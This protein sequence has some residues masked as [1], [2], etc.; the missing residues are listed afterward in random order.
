MSELFRN[1]ERSTEEARQMEA[2][3]RENRLNLKALLFTLAIVMAPFFALI[4]SVDLAMGVLAA[5]LGFT[6]WL[7]W[8]A[9]R[10]VGPLLSSRLRVVA[11]LNLCIML[12]V[13]LI[14]VLHLR[15]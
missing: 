3:R 11:I 15:A 13:L 12:V 2:I 9:S 10:D 7:T 6:T 8:K 14:L 1:E 4:F 5:G